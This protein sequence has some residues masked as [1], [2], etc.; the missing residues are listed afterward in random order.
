MVF[1]NIIAS[2]ILATFNFKKIIKNTQY[3]Q[4]DL[5]SQTKNDN[6]F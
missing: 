4:E 1:I 6:I 5:F 2:S 3:Q